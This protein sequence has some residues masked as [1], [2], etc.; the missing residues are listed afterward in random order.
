MDQDHSQA[1]PPEINP[2]P[3]S[4]ANKHWKEWLSAAIIIIVIA[5]AA[6]LVWRGNKGG[7]LGTFTTPTPTAS[8]SSFATYHEY[9][10][11]IHPQ[12]KPYSVDAN[13]SQV[14]NLDQF[15]TSDTAVHPTLSDAT[16]SLLAKNLFAVLP[17]HGSSEFYQQYEANR[18]LYIPNF[19]TTD[20]IVHN[21]HLVFDYLLKDLEQKKL[22]DEVKNLNA[23]MLKA[24]EDQYDAVKGTS[25][26]NA[27]KRNVAF[28]AVASKLS[29]PSVAVPSYVSD[30][31]NQ[32]LALINAHNEL[33]PSPVMN[34]GETNNIVEALKEDYSQYIP[35][36]HYDKTDQLKAYFKTMMW[37]GRLTFRFKSD[38]ETKSAALITT[39]LEQ[40]SQ[41]DSWDKIYEPTT[42]FVGVSD[43]ITFKQLKDVMDKV[44]GG[45]PDAPSLA[46]DDAK[47]A[48][49]LD[50]A[51]KMPAPMINSVPIF[52]PTIQ[53]DRAKEISGF[54]F[55]GQRFTVD[56]SI[57]QQ[58]VYRDV[59]PKPNGDRR[60]LPKGLD[61]PAALGSDE[62]LNILKSTGE[63]DYP[64]YSDNMGKLR[65]YLSKLP[66]PV[67]TQ[68]LYWGWIY[69]LLPGLDTK[70][71]GYPSFMQNT[72]WTDKQ[73]N[74]FEGSWTEL[75]HDTILYAKQVYAELGGGGD[76]KQEDDRGY[77]EPNPYGYARLASLLRMTSEGLQSRGLLTDAAR[78]N[79]EKMQDLVLS[80]KTISE[81]ELNG[82]A[83]SN[84]E[85]DLI[86]S[87]GGQLEHFWLEANKE[88]MAASGLDQSNYLNQNPA[89]IVADVATDPNGSVLEEGTG[90]TQEILVIVP[91]DG[92]LKLASGE[93]YSH[94]EFPWPID[95]RLTDQKWRDMVSGQSD[96]PLPPLPD[97]TKSFIAAPQQ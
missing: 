26:E 79:L 89:A 33:V 71:T 34:L 17:D 27:A 80:L 6:F 64:K 10:V 56:A 91:V 2:P 61:I 69:S 81:K 87:Y 39:A 59:D 63:T 3:A 40:K 31:V 28:F 47:F 30:P 95:D 9:P 32:E 52:D 7:G 85:Y 48:Q 29:D 62:A 97:W 75:K 51:R 44:Y 41:G 74:T 4:A 25:W 22:A 20:S 37:Y 90:Y 57:F 23:L 86:R 46:K 77:V 83:L 78:D 21:Y 53:P 60:L 84:D 50:A 66:V 11:D 19:V 1:T 36:G 13:L 94:Y 45:A 12:V 96:K 70:L 35:R 16:K 43:D 92:K 88:E 67:W 54:R 55:M 72:A 58:L 18:Y 49:F 82:V 5:A 68:N 73:L 65:Q 8:A 38:D 15:G 42:F 14:V 76:I 24:S 93:V